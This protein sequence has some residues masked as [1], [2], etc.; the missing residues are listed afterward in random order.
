MR[1][2]FPA[3]RPR[4]LAS[5]ALLCALTTLPACSLIDV[6]R[7]QG[8]EQEDMSSAGMDMSLVDM[9]TPE[10]MSLDMASDMNAEDMPADMTSGDMAA[11]DDMPADAGMDMLADMPDMPAPECGG[12]GSSDYEILIPVERKVSV[13][14][15]N[16][17]NGAMAVV[18]A[19]GYSRSDANTRVVSLFDGED[20]S[21]QLTAANTG[22]SSSGYSFGFSVAISPCPASQRSRRSCLGLLS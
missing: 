7:G 11:P 21:L 4:A 10:D 15:H 20:G 18:G 3:N 1:R 13:R 5:L 8:G 22:A 14:S 17:G 6:I 12:E 19:G 2:G 16:I 9:S